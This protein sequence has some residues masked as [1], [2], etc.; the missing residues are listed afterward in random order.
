MYANA[1]V[2]QLSH[3]HQ[4]PS[5]GRPPSVRPFPIAKPDNPPK[6]D[7]PAPTDSPPKP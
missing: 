4:N 6:F 7:G 2:R 5:F 1:R 3:G